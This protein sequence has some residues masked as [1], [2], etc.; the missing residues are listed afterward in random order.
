MQAKY[1]TA[2]ATIKRLED[3]LRKADQTLL[4]LFDKENKEKEAIRKRTRIQNQMKFRGLYNTILD[5]LN[6]GKKSRC[7]DSDALEIFD[8]DLELK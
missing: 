2:Y 8:D 4:H 5:I 3:P 1:C 6:V 7:Y